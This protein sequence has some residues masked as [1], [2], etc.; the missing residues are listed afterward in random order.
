MYMRAIGYARV[1]TTKQDLARQR[2]K[3]TNFCRENNYELAFILEDFGISGATLDRKGYQTLNSLTEN[4]CDVIVVSEISRLSRKEQITEALNDIQQILNNGISV[5]LLDDSAKVYKAKENL[6]ITELLLL[7]IQL[8]G[9]AQERN[10]IKRKN[11]DGKQALFKSNPYAVVD[12]KIP[13]GFRSVPN[14]IS[15]RPKYLL[16]QNPDE[17]KVIKKIFELVLEGKTLY[18]VMQYLNDR[19]IMIRKGMPSTSILSRII[20]NELYIGIR[21]RTQ[22]FGKEKGKEDVAIQHIEPIISEEDFKN[23]GERI[24]NNNKYVSTA[25]VYFNPFKGIIKC[26]CGRSMMV[27]PKKRVGDFTVLT[28][29]CSC[30]ESRNSRKFCSANIDEISYELTNSV[31]KSLFLQRNQ[32]IKDYF[33]ETGLARVKELNEI[34]EGIEKKI[35]FADLKMDELTRRT[36][37]NLQKLSK[38]TNLQFIA[39]LEQDQAK[40]DAEI[41][42]VETEKSNYK[43]K[44]RELLNQ[45]NSIKKA[46]NNIDAYER[47]FNI[48]NDEL[49]DLYHLYLETIEYYPITPM[50]GFYKVKF[51]SGYSLYIAIT[52]VRFC[53][54]AFLINGNGNGSC[55]VDVRTGDITYSYEEAESASDINNLN[56]G[57]RTIK[58]TVNI[59]DFFDKNFNKMPFALELGLDLSYRT[60]YKEQLEKTAIQKTQPSQT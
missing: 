42:K 2:C 30:I 38:L 33:K 51:K 55:T 31:I 9:A 22:S 43:R 15:N 44:E 60:K 26:R 8:W 19:N 6:N 46:Y 35:G 47:V 10:E 59:R 36:E 37:Q 27:K 16:E 34:I 29:R 7:I 1:S 56:F 4:D 41:K 3:I 14:T 20:H 48:S 21:R 28:Y 53:P 39:A 24:E 52:K 13:F 5:I 23:A 50:K 32:E 54:Q 45:I 11:Q 25:K 12:A 49:T 58:G 17:V 18:G 40:T 57:W